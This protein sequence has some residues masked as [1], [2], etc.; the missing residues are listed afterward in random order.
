MAEQ[1]ADCAESVSFLELVSLDQACRQNRGVI[2]N[3]ADSDQAQGRLHAQLEHVCDAALLEQNFAV[4]RRVSQKG[5]RQHVGRGVGFL[6]ET[7]DHVER[8][9]HIAARH[10]AEK[11]DQFEIRNVHARK[12]VDA[13]RE[14]AAVTHSDHLRASRSRSPTGETGRPTVPVTSGAVG[15]R[16]VRARPR[17]VRARTFAAVRLRAGRKRRPARRWRRE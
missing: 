7:M 6:G 3:R 17:T 11:R 2:V 1:L 5:E 13:S 16:R 4:L 14:R 9:R 10:A 8:R 12:M 15:R